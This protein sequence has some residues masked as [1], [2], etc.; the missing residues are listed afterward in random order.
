MNEVV[1]KQ[2]EG[3]GAVTVLYLHSRYDTDTFAFNINQCRYQ[4]NISKIP[5]IHTSMII[6]CASSD[7]QKITAATVGV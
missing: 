2:F 6:L 7:I 3:V 4:S 1:V 5:L